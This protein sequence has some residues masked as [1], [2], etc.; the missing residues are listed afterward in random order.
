MQKNQKRMKKYIWI[1]ALALGM[2]ACSSEKKNEQKETQ[3]TPDSMAAA[4]SATEEGY[5]GA[6]ITE[7]G[8]KPLN[9]LT[10]LMGEQKELQTKL[11]GTITECCQKKGCWMKMD[12][13][14][15]QTMR[16]TFKD[17]EFF[18]PKN[19]GG[20][21]A[22]IEGKAYYEETSVEELK[23]Y[24]EDAGKSKEEIAAITK[25]EK[26]LVFEANGVIIK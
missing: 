19:A 11:S 26:E 14:N 8:A 22:V 5:Y 15:G 21:Q 23:H 7:E 18:V 10:A 9:E 1:A 12:M 16:V 17:Y 13:G 3:E 20:K 6:R 4:E 2:T 24:A 25:P